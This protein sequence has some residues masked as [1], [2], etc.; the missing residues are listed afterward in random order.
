MNR[1]ILLLVVS[2][3]VDWQE[4]WLPPE[5]GGQNR[6]RGVSRQAQ[7]R[8]RRLRRIL[9]LASA[10]DCLRTWPRSS[11][12]TVKIPRPRWP[13]GPTRRSNA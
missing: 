5:D 9:P 8:V 1:P 3:A 13:S 12:P 6:R 11:Q 7:N 4:F 10:D 2:S